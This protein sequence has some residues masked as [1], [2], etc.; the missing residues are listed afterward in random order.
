MPPATNVPH[1]MPPAPTELPAAPQAFYPAWPY[2]TMPP[3]MQP[4]AF[5]PAYVPGYAPAYFSQPAYYSMPGYSM[6]PGVLPAQ[7]MGPR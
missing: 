1:Y 3:L 5:Q 7:W 6:P 2:G 4:V